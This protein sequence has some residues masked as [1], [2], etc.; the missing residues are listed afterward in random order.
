MEFFWGD[1]RQ[2]FRRSLL[3]AACMAVTL[4]SQA[5]DGR[6][7]GNTESYGTDIPAMSG[8]S[9]QNNVTFPTG[10]RYDGWTIGG[11][12]GI[13]LNRDN[14]QFVAA[15]D[16]TR[17]GLGPGGAGQ[18]SLFTLEPVF[19]PEQPGYGI[20][21]T[22]VTPLNNPAWQPETN[23]LESVRHDPSG[24]GL[25]LS[26]ESENVLYHLHADGTTRDTIRPPETVTG[27]GGNIQLEGMTFTHEGALWVIREAPRAQD[28]G[29]TRLSRLSEDGRVLAQYPY[30]M[31]GISGNGVSELLAVSSSSFLV[32]ERAWDGKGAGTAPTSQSHNSIRIYRV[33]VAGA[34]DISGSASLSAGSTLPVSKTLIFDSKAL[35]GVLNT[36]DTKVDNVEGM[37]FGPTLPDG[38]TSLILVSD[39][40]FSTTQRKTQ[41]IILRLD[42]LLPDEQY[43]DGSTPMADGRAGG[44]NGAWQSGMSAENWTR[45]GGLINDGW[46]GKTAIFRGA[47]GTV[48]VDNSGGQVSARELRFLVSGYTLIGQALGM[49][50]SGLTVSVPAAGD[51]AVIAAPLTGSS[52]LTKSGAGAL[53]LNGDSTATG[54]TEVHAG[55]LTVNGTLPGTMTVDSSAVL[56]GSGHTG[57]IT[58]RS[59]AT[60]SPGAAG[61]TLT[62]A[63]DVTLEPGS[64][65]VSTISADGRSDALHSN[66]RITLSSADL[67]AL[68]ASTGNL[69]TQREVQSLDGRRFRILDAASGF[70][71]HFSTVSPAWLF[72]GVHPDY[73]AT[74]VTLTAGRNATPFTALAGTANSRAVAAAADALPAGHPVRE[75]LL[76]IS[77]AGEARSAFS[78]LSGQLHADVLES[79]ADQSAAVRTAL[80]DHLQSAGA[81]SATEAQ[82]GHGL[83]GKLLGAQGHSAGQGGD[84]GY[85]DSAYGALFGADLTGRYARAGAALSYTR[86]SVDGGADGSATGDNGW[87]S[88]YGS[89]TPGAL[90]LSAGSVLG[91]HRAETE[92][93]VAYGTQ[94]DTDTSHYG[95]RSVQVFGSAAY[96]LLSGP[97][98]LA[99]FTGLRWVSLSRNALQE[100]GGAAALSAGREEVHAL[101]SVAGLEGNTAWQISPVEQ[102]HVY[103]RAGWQHALSAVSRDATLH[104]STGNAFTVRAPDAPR[105]AMLLK[106]GAE[107][108]AG[109]TVAV[110]AG[111]SGLLSVRHQAN[112]FEA[113]VRWQF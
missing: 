39:N 36:W 21:F 74:G 103:G 91:V 59:G 22:G 43:W 113:G 29:I 8:L 20:R 6:F 100:S 32:M 10:E 54:P 50:P 52:P 63:G 42:S 96:D 1:Q 90:T 28:S 51:T 31:D 84:Y 56:G 48:T 108:R 87:L 7:S 40:N 65:Y 70:S 44:G 4:P 109:D 64:H 47:P 97:A 14:G 25:W 106:A 93:R 99:S 61:N 24:D 62:A 81:P 89:W 53:V 26:S 19:T 86:S 78:T 69:L 33:D 73:D 85:D 67:S 37:S 15:R 92:R 5:D 27:S 83:W 75:S 2:N 80:E 76:G 18:T 49:D 35:A 34:P 82:A 102:L 77:S 72:L 17:L 95:A 94:R 58:L 112:S 46:G 60:L 105:D 30:R 9:Y 38:H 41:F 110:T 111:W 88:T 68:S 98:V 3:C 107:W 101:Q 104:F 11:L 55:R 16:N 57:G 71:G 66:G 23:G 12:S 13:D 79:L 45:A